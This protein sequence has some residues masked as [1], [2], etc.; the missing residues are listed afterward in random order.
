L[1]FVW[2]AAALSDA[3][4]LNLPLQPPC[5][6]HYHLSATCRRAGSWSALGVRDFESAAVRLD[7]AGRRISLLEGCGQ[8]AWI[9]AAQQALSDYCRRRMVDEK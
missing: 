8:K 5:F 3:S 9:T 7:C 6:E 4:H 1:D 2:I